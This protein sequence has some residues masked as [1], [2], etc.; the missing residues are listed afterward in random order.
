MNQ[1]MDKIKRNQLQEKAP[2]ETQTKEL[3]LLL[4]HKA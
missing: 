4:G 3:S 2:I 1:Q